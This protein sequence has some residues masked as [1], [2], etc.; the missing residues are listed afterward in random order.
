LCFDNTFVIA[1]V[2][3]VLPW[4]MW[5][6]VPH[7]NAACCGHFFFRHFLAPYNAVEQARLCLPLVFPAARQYLVAALRGTSS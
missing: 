1:A 5:P 7:C 3:V 2:N 4:S 6:I